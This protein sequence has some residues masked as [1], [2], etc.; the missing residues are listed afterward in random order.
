[1]AYQVRV[2]DVEYY[3]Q[4]I[5]CQWAC[6]ARTDAR[7]YIAAIARGDLEAAYAIA[8][9]PNPMASICGRICNAPCEGACRR[10]SHDAPISIRG[11]KRVITERYGAEAQLRLPLLWEK[12]P[13]PNV[14][15]H[16]GNMTARDRITLQEL[17]TIPGRTT[18]K[19]AVIGSGPAGLAAAHDL[20][21]LGHQVTI[22]EA[23]PDAGGMMR[24]GIPPYR[25]SRE[26]LDA[27]ITAVLEMGVELRLNTPIGTPGQPTLADLRR[28][29]NAVFIGAGLGKGRDLNIPGVEM[30]GVLKAIDFLINVNRGYKIELG[31]RVLV[32]GGGNVA[33]D[34]ARMAVRTSE[35]RTAEQD[36]EEQTDALH[37]ALDVARTALRMGIAEVHMIALEDWHEL[38]AQ[39]IE[40]KEALEEGISIH[41]RLGP[42]RIIGR[43]GRVTGL[44][45][46]Q[47]ASVF[48]AEG[49]FNPKFI[50]HTE[51]VMEGDTVILAIGQAA[52]LGLLGTAPDVTVSGR[53]L[54]VADAH[55]RT[56]AADIFAGGDVVHGPRLLIEA[57]GDGARAA[58]ALDSF[59][60]QRKPIRVNQVHFEELPGHK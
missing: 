38:P 9:A 52:D 51:S 24:L 34:A 31:K 59:I 41:T 36:V 28:D 17:A 7:G 16:P 3:Q 1:M 54:I 39:P 37:A 56:S 53:G 19:V 13:A 26:L 60:Q 29:F 18:G 21:L 55:G 42:Q 33:V 44:E 57:V 30:D 8:R 12:T 32:I 27:E 22:F 58:L 5:K 2:P 46:I 15:L 6:P 10:G 45:T 47:V 11:L 43:G 4:L 50:P 49:R 35:S 23:Q 25:L 20:V 48:D 14:F 40:I